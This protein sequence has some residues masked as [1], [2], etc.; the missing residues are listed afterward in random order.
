MFRTGE[1]CEYDE[2]HKLLA[3]HGSYLD[4]LVEHTGSAAAEKLRAMAL[5]AH[6]ERV[7]PEDPK[8]DDIAL[9]V[10][11]IWEGSIVTCNNDYYL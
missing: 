7:S 1:L 11:Q 4:R 5:A 6:N 2:P 8:S 3:R 10:T 9:Y